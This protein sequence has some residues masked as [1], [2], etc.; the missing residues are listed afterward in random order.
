MNSTR[1]VPEKPVFVK[2]RICYT[3]ANMGQNLP[4]IIVIVGQT[5]SGKSALGIEIAKAVGGEVLSVDSR[6]VYKGMNI[7]TAKPEPDKVTEPVISND[8]RSLFAGG[9]PVMVEGVP[10]WGFDLVEPNEDYSVSEFKQYADE[11]MADMLRRGVVPVLVGGTGLWV[12]AVVDN[13]RLAETPPDPVLRTELEAR[14]LEDLF[15]QYKRLDPDGAEVIDRDNKRR[16]VRALEVTLK[17]GTPFSAQLIP[18]EPLY[19]PLILGVQRSQEELARRI[20]ERVDVMIAKGLFQEVRALRE[21][22]GINATAM[23]AI[24]YQEITRF[25]DGQWSAEEAVEQIKRHTKQYAKRQMT[26][27][28]KDT[29]VVWIEETDEAVSRAKTFLNT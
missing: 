1:K 9:K 22:Y 7:G 13:L 16:V 5:A 10:H 25:M 17:T 4:K 21:R 29:R 27:W 15:A 19:T 14:S 24:G 20:D 28:R 8:I 26:W 6:T 3:E 18:Q 11:R 12:R 23:T 2:R